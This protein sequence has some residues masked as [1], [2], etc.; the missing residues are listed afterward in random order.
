MDLRGKRV[1]MIGLGISGM[2]AAKLLKD[3]GAQVTVRDN[4]TT[5]KVAERADALRKLGMR[6]ELGPE[7]QP[8]ADYDLAVLSPGINPRAPIVETLHQAGLPMFGEL[9]LAYRFCECPIVAITGTNG[10]TTTAASALWRRATSARRFPPRCA[11]ART[12][13]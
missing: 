9:E 11:K 5:G 1:V 3:K 2:E 13:T 7:V 12:W 6:V 8:N 4:A 10:K